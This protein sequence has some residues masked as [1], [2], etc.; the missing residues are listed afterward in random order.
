MHYLADRSSFNL[1]V[2]STREEGIAACVVGF[3]KKKKKIALLDWLLIQRITNAWDVQNLFSTAVHCSKTNHVSVSF[4][5]GWPVGHTTSAR[6]YSGQSISC[7]LA[8]PWGKMGYLTVFVKKNV[9][10]SKKDRL[11][12]VCV[13]AGRGQPPSCTSPH[14]AGSEESVCHIV[15]MATIAAIKFH[16]ILTGAATISQRYRL[17]WWHKS[18]YV[19]I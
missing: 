16:L 10:S 3:C 19:K 9:Q 4:W 5:F 14:W 8:W 12:Y 13:A 7:P 2:E 18:V 17:R 1:D 6:R 11:V 15:R